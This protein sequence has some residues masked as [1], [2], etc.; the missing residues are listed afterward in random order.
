MRDGMKALITTMAHVRAQQDHAGKVKDVIKG[1]SRQYAE[2]VASQTKRLDV[3]FG[4][5][6]LPEYDADKRMRLTREKG[7]LDQIQNS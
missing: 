3:S 4:D 6:L 2:S 1:R 7:M 5:A